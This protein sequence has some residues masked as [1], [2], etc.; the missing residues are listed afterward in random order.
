MN[1][2]KLA[3]PI[4][5]HENNIQQSS[6]SFGGGQHPIQKVIAVKNSPEDI[7]HRIPAITEAIASYLKEP[8]YSHFVAAVKGTSL[9]PLQEIYRVHQ[10]KKLP[11]DALRPHERQ[12]RI[13]LQLQQK[14][15]SDS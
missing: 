9:R 8:D 11:L 7:F 1:T 6:L 5:N 3:L 15:L 12:L 14:E 4:N 2:I 13:A 10:Q